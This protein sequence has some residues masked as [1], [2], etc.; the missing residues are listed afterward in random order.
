MRGKYFL[1]LHVWKCLYNSIIVIFI[2][3][4]ITCLQNVKGIFPMFFAFRVLVEKTAVI[5]S[6]FSLLS[7]FFPPLLK[8]IQ[9]CDSTVLGIHEAFKSENSGHPF[10]GT[11]FELF[12]WWFSPSC[13]CDFV[14]FFLELYYLDVINQFSTFLFF[15]SFPLLY[16]IFPLSYN[17]CIEISILFSVYVL[18]Y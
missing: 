17:S 16:G 4:E 7:L 1:T 11:F 18:Y 3:L 12:S 2:R 5:S 8:L 14:F 9:I 15:I 13:F 10:P 6:L